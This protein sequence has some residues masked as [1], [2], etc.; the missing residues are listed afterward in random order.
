MPNK[1]SGAQAGA[2]ASDGVEP[3][4]WSK[5]RMTR[6]LRLATA[7]L[8]A[9]SSR[10]V[11][12]RE[13]EARWYCLALHGGH[14]FDVEKRISDAGVE[15]FVPQEIWVT[16]KNGR[17]IEGKEA[18]LPGYALVRIVPSAAAFQG[19][20]QQKSIFGFVGRGA[21]YHIVRDNDVAVL[22]GISDK[23]DVSRMPVD[24]SI[25]QGHRARVTKGVFAGYDC[26]VLQVMSGRNPRVRVSVEAFGELSRD[27]TM[28]LAFIE[29]L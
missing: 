22:K 10:L 25:G 17:K 14:E 3:S 6:A 11:A 18:L 24:R 15:I 28:A 27:V 1:F 9:A 29:K 12:E 16:I 7:Q 13:K 19:L 8:A 23:N 4:Q 26:V 5:D 21:S 2:C 20:L